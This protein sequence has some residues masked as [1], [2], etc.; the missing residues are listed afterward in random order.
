M[1]HKI[2]KVSEILNNEDFIGEYIAH[3]I[4]SKYNDIKEE[5]YK[6]YSELDDKSKINFYKTFAFLG[7]DEKLV[8]FAFRILDEEENLSVKAT[9]LIMLGDIADEKI[10][11]RL[12]KFLK[13][14]DRRIRANTVE[15]LS[16]IGDRKI[17]DLLIP[18]I[19]EEKD[20]RVLANTA[21][22][23][24]KFE[25][26]REKVLQVFK[27]MTEDREKWMRASALYAFGETEV[28]EF[29]EFLLESVEDEDE[30]ICRNALIALVGYS[31]ILSRQK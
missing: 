28:S 29:L 14:S 20:N 1:N 11:P 16:K 3:E 7:Y 4:Y 26:I 2:E 25:D 27:K 24:W 31:E 21:I 10:I 9:I 30:D 12:A 18:V 22:A 19:E 6:C 23:L 8:E 13:D 17:I 15:A 5:F